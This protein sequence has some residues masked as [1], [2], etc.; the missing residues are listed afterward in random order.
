MGK[1]ADWN[2]GKPGLLKFT[3]GGEPQSLMVTPANMNGQMQVGQLCAFKLA[4]DGTSH[5]QAIDCVPLP[6]NTTADEAADMIK[7]MNL[8]PAT[9]DLIDRMNLNAATYERDFTLYIPALTR[10]G[11]SLL[12]SELEH[13][14]SMTDRSYSFGNR[15]IELLNTLRLDGVQFNMTY[16]V[17]GDGAENDLRDGLL[18]LLTSVIKDEILA[19]EKKA[20]QINL[21]TINI[22]KQGMASKCEGY[23]EDPHNGYVVEIATED[24]ISA[25]FD[26][27]RD[28]IE[29]VFLKLIEPNELGTSDTH[30]LKTVAGRVLQDNSSTLISVNKGRPIDTSAIFFMPELF[31]ELCPRFGPLANEPSYSDSPDGTKKPALSL[32]HSEHSHP[33]SV[34]PPWDGGKAST[35]TIFCDGSL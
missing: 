31:F 30:Y 25:T 19:Q 20:E 18:V 8:N 2:D 21:V 29:D 34:L 28:T 12:M 17:W 16:Y 11:H 1:V 22:Y 14:W 5:H 6:L 32:N 7:R 4:H 26:Y 24:I 10:D 9:S 13:F 35:K 15:A 27:D 3:M 33:E 23:Y